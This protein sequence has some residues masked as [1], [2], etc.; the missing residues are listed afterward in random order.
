M[1]DYGL[2]ILMFLLGASMVLQGVQRIRGIR[3][4]LPDTKTRLAM[5]S[6]SEEEKERVLASH[7]A[8]NRTQ[9]MIRF[10]LGL[11]VLVVG[12]YLLVI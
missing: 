4:T 8:S 1:L 11:F 9:G 6:M 5:A 12:V 3:R 2:P 10:A 7:Q